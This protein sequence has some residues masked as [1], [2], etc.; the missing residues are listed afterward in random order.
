MVRGGR[1]GQWLQDSCHC[2]WGQTKDA[3]EGSSDVTVEGVDV[4]AIVVVVVVVAPVGDEHRGRAV[5]VLTA[6][7]VA[8]VGVLSETNVMWSKNLLSRA[9]TSSSDRPANVTTLD[10][11]SEALLAAAAPP[12]RD[13]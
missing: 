13:V 2:L 7:V 1:V 3:L 8:V 9:D 11:W 10:V 5:A 12:F 4:D 6:L